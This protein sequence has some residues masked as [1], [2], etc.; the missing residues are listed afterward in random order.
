MNCYDWLK[1]MHQHKVV[2]FCGP[3]CCIV[4]NKYIYVYMY[5]SV[6]YS[7]LL[8]D[9]FSISTFYVTA[10]FL[11]SLFSSK[12]YKQYPIMITWKK[13]VWNLCKFIKYKKRQNHMY[14]SIH[15]L[16]HD[17]QNWAQEHP[18]STE[19]PWDVSTTWLGSPCGKFSWLDMILKGTYLSI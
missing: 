18:V 16:C 2:N 8:I 10:L 14:V 17:T 3:N 11:N 5:D 12:F 1:L 15:G 4:I 7:Q 9:Y 6:K 19:D 13:F